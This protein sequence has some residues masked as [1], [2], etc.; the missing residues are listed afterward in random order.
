MRHATIN[1]K[2][3]NPVVPFTTDKTS[4]NPESNKWDLTRN[5]EGV[6]YN[7]FNPWYCLVLSTRGSYW[8]VAVF[9]HV[10]EM[11]KGNVSWHCSKWDR[12]P[13]R[14]GCPFLKISA[15]PLGADRRHVNTVSHFYITFFSHSNHD[16]KSNSYALWHAFMIQLVIFENKLHSGEMT[17]YE[18]E[19]ARPKL[20]S[21]HHHFCKKNKRSKHQ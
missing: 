2:D 14:K 11:I 3:A 9:M 18:F 20:T 21:V 4:T 12:R 7:L 6:F 5:Y 1:I 17:V 13:E 10:C 19:S 15:T 8:S 16:I